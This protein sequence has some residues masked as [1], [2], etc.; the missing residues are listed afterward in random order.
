[1]DGVSREA[2]ISE[3]ADMNKKLLPILKDN[4]QSIKGT[5][6]CEF[7]YSA[8]SKASGRSAYFDDKSL[9]KDEIE[10]ASEGEDNA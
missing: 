5:Q 6:I 2:I 8:Y 4:L 9:F 1:M 7:L 3:A 10:N